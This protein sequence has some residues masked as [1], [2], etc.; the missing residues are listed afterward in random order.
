LERERGEE[1]E[2]DEGRGIEAGAAAEGAETIMA[3]S[4]SSGIRLSPLKNFKLGSPKISVS[5]LSS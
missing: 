5:S 3:S 1:D 4:S 2:D